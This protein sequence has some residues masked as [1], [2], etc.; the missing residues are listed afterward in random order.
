MPV[1]VVGAISWSW[2]EVRPLA[3]LA[4]KEGEGGTRTRAR[5]R[6]VDI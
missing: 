1:V 5:S 4:G 3:S 2:I 6:R